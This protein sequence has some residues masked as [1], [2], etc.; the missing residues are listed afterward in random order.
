MSVADNTWHFPLDSVTLSPLDEHLE[1]G[2]EQ[3]RVAAESLALAQEQERQR[4]SADAQRLYAR[5]L[6]E[7]EA[8][9]KSSAD[10]TDVRQKRVFLLRAVGN[11]PE[12][13]ISASG[14][15]VP[16]KVLRFPSV[17]PVW[18]VITL[19]LLHGWRMIGDLLMYNTDDQDSD[20]TRQKLSMV[21]DRLHSLVKYLARRYDSKAHMLLTI[22]EINSYIL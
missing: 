7:L 8:S 9:G 10:L 20:S 21:A 19:S 14:S 4:H 15:R 16:T 22:S 13:L 3:A 17:M 2:R 11:I 18:T 12:A 5:A 1:P 6:L